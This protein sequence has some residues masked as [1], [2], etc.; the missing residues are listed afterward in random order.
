MQ[1]LPEILLFCFLV[2]LYCVFVFAKD[3]FILLRKN[4][5]L[6]QLFNIS[7]S[8]F[9]ITLFFARMTFV[10]EHFNYK[11]LD[12]L[13]FFL[14]PYFPGL[15]FAGGIIGGIL[16]I[17]FFCKKKNF[18]FGRIFDITSLSFL[19]SIAVGLLFFFISELFFM[20]AGLFLL[21]GASI[22][23]LFVFI[24]LAVIFSG[25]LLKEGSIGFLSVSFASLCLLS[26]NIFS[27]YKKRIL[28]FP[29]ED[30]ILGM[31]F[32]IFLILFFRNETI[33]KVSKKIRKT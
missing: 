29:P 30:I 11:Y 17:V 2:F 19:F 6:E 15:S 20:K 1:F 26:L 3:D 7:F 21:L 12:P 4:V 13:V 32:F 24:L 23:F 25:T 27:T 33:R 9:F 18:P 16:C 14:F 8:G 31:N 5:A 22:L 10:I 28:Q